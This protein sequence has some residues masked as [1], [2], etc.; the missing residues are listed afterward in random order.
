MVATT[1]PKFASIC[2]RVFLGDNAMFDDDEKPI[3]YHLPTGHFEL[4]PGERVFLDKN[5]MGIS[6][7]R[8]REIPESAM[9]PELVRAYVRNAAM[10]EGGEWRAMTERG[11]LLCVFSVSDLAKELSGGRD[12]RTMHPLDQLF[13]SLASARLGVSAV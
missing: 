11:E 13:L 1:D 3:R 9:T 8:R 10:T 6:W 7:A 12:C 5:K 2:H 4:D